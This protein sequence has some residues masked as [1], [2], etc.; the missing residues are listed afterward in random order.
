MVKMNKNYQLISELL[1][2]L[3]QGIHPNIDM[4]I[5][6]PSL[7]A[8]VPKEQ[9]EDARTNGIKVDQNGLIHVYFTRIP[10]TVDSYNDYLNSHSPLKILISKLKN[11]KDQKITIKPINFP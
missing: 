1:S 10:E 11:V 2:S 6:K 4:L 5:T 9:L 7:Y 3:D 8:Y